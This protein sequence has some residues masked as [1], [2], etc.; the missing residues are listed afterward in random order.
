MVL[1]IVNYTGTSLI[2]GINNNPPYD[3]HYDMYYDM[4]YWYTFDIFELEE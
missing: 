1:C 2:F 3:M 4:Y